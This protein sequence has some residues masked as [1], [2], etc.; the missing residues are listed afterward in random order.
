MKYPHISRRYLIGLDP[1]LW[2][3]VIV[4]DWIKIDWDVVE[5]VNW[6]NCSSRDL[7]LALGFSGRPLRGRSADG[8]MESWED[9][10][11]YGDDRMMDDGRSI[12]CGARDWR[13]EVSG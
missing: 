2:L 1:F 3:S 8:A 11:G 13:M 4:S 10:V 6:I 7:V 12:E 5:Y 9:E